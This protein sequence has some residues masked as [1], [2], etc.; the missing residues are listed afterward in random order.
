MHFVQYYSFKWTVFSEFI[1][2]KFWTRDDTPK[3]KKY[4]FETTATDT[5]LVKNVFDAVKTII[6][7]NILEDVGLR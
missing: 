4:F 6:L 2:K 7:E 3:R 5:G 1:Q